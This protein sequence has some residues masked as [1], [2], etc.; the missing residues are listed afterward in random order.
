MLTVCATYSEYCLLDKKVIEILVGLHAVI[1]LPPPQP[2]I[3]R[4]YQSI[5]FLPHQFRDYLLSVE[6]GFTRYARLGMPRNTTIGD[7]QFQ[8]TIYMF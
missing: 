8:Y 5:N 6:V 1:L 3:Q 4:N 2:V 7:T